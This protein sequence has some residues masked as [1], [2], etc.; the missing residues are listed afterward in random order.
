MNVAFLH[1]HESFH[2]EYCTFNW[3]QDLH[4]PIIIIFSFK[5]RRLQAEVTQHN[6]GHPWYMNWSDTW[7]SAL[8]WSLIKLGCRA[9]L[10]LFMANIAT[11]GPTSQFVCWC[12]HLGSARAVSQWGEWS[13]FMLG[14]LTWPCSKWVSQQHFVVTS[15]C[16]APQAL[17]LLPWLYGK[18]GVPAGWVALYWAP[19]LWGPALSGSQQCFNQ[20]DLGGKINSHLWC[21][22]CVFL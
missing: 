14:H 20:G 4:A 9:G 13:S 10:K 18:Q 21:K 17:Y 11:L 8:D 19:S 5:G 7:C 3:L 16:T 6:R 15:S 22:C 12:G 2:F 1:Y